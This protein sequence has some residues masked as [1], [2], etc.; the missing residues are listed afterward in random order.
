MAGER[1]SGNDM[2]QALIHLTGRRGMLSGK[3]A[4]LSILKEGK[5]REFRGHNTNYFVTH[6]ETRSIEEQ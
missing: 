1:S 4:L 2:S 5:I 3:D 6:G